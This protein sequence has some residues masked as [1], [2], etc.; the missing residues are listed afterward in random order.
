MNAV[1]M[2]DSV[3]SIVNDDCRGAHFHNWISITRSR[4]EKESNKL[5]I[6]G[7]RN[8][9]V[10]NVRSASSKSFYIQRNSIIISL[11]YA[12]QML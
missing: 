6:Q 8:K 3:A 12:K 4:Y 2:N 10:Q 7:K 1:D 11:N 5:W 9:F